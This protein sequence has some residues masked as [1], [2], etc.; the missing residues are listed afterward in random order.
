[1]AS[2]WAKIGRIVYGAGRDDVHEMYFEERDRGTVDYVLDAYRND[3]SVRGGVLR[4]EC[5]AYYVGPDEPVPPGQW[6][7]L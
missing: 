2:I 6:V 4:Q 7:N 5:A 1:M 3:L